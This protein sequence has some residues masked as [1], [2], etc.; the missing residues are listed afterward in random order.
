[1]ATRIVH[2]DWFSSIELC[3]FIYL[4]SVD[5]YTKSKKNYFR[6]SYAPY[7]GAAVGALFLVLISVLIIKRRELARTFHGGSYSVDSS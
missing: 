6:I 2:S 7:I 5:Y 3:I 4:H 1:M